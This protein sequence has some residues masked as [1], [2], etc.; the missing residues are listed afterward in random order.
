MTD[1]QRQRFERSLTFAIDQLNA[2]IPFVLHKVSSDFC[3]QSSFS[4]VD[5]RLAAHVDAPGECQVA[6]H[7]KDL[8]KVEEVVNPAFTSALEFIANGRRHLHL[9]PLFTTST[10]RRETEVMVWICSQILS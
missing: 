6:L 10:N 1:L 7:V 2:D 9:W 5:F 8:F 3:A 4:A